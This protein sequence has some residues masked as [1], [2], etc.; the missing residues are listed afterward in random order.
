MFDPITS[1]SNLV[2]KGLDKL[3][4]D[5]GTKEKLAFE[6]Q[7]FILGQ[8]L[9]EDS[10]FRNFILQYEGKAE[11]TPTLINYLRT[12]VRPVLTYVISGAYIWGWVHPEAYTET[13]MLV[14]K[15]MV[16]IVLLFWFGDRMIQRSGILDI[17]NKKV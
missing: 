3:V 9:Q 10:D 12:S 8:G 14:L 13:Q 15:P 2:S 5:K 16:I 4:S 6:L 17:F 11:D 1:I 7:K